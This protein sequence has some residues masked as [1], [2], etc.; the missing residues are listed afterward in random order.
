MQP[1]HPGEAA[2]DSPPPILLELRIKELQRL[3]APS[4]AVT[5][6]VRGSGAGARGEQ[7]RMPSQCAACVPVFARG[8]VT[9]PPA[10]PRRPGPMQRG[11][12]AGLH[13]QTASRFALSHAHDALLLFPAPRALLD[14][15]PPPPLSLSALLTG[16]RL[17]PRPHHAPHPRP[18]RLLHRGG[19]DPPGPAQAGRG[20]RVQRL[21]GAHGLGCGPVA[22]ALRDLPGPGRPAGPG[23]AGRAAG[24]A[25]TLGGG[26]PGA[27]AQRRHRLLHDPPGST[28][29]GSPRG[30]RPPAPAPPRREALAAAAHRRLPPLPCPP[31][32]ALGA[33]GCGRGAVHQ[34]ARRAGGGPGGRGGG[35]ARCGACGG[36]HGQL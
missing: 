1:P 24:D 32:P 30:R 12:G 20:P 28:D 34:C 31:Q 23:R 6:Q 2:P 35:R 10:A 11:L 29:G 17:R 15:D 16:P 13:G 21:A 7:E 14:L 36:G 8:P 22:D 27:D 33:G 18:Q 3:V 25:G 5:V 19:L 4:G 9:P 26:P